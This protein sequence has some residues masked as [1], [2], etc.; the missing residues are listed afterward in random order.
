MTETDNSVL[1]ATDVGHMF[2]SSHGYIGIAPHETQVGNQIRILRGGYQP[3]ISPDYAHNQTTGVS[4]AVGNAYVQG[5]M[6]G[7][8]FEQPKPFI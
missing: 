3:C 2:T 8:I 5:I 7:Q 6:A 4:T 1:R